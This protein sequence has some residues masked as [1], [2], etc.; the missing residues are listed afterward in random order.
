M[1]R[2]KLAISTVTDRTGAPRANKPEGWVGSDL[3]GH[4]FCGGPTVRMPARWAGRRERRG[5]CLEFKTGKGILTEILSRQKETF[6]CSQCVIT[7]D[8]VRCFL[9]HSRLEFPAFFLPLP[10][11]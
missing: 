6:L 5:S 3:W 4:G 2:E 7:A 9:S 8:S 1:C 10:F 11:C